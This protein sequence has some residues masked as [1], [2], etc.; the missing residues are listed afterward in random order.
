MRNLNKSGS[1][2][3]H[4]LSI[5]NSFVDELAKKLDYVKTLLISMLCISYIPEK[6]NNSLKTLEGGLTRN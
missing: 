5:K 4:I 1:H 3:V 6:E 2:A